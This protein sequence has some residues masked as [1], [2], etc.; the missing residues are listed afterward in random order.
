MQNEDII[1]TKWVH[2]SKQLGQTGKILIIHTGE[3]WGDVSDTL[4]HTKETLVTGK[5]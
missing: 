5:I 3:D 2:L 1:V 4:G